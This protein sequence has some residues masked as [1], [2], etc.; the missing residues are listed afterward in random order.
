MCL[1]ALLS[2]MGSL[3]SRPSAAE[4][5]FRCENGIKFGETPEPDV[6]EVKCRSG[7]CGHAPG[8]VVLHRF[9]VSTGELISTARFAEPPN[10]KET[11]SAAQHY[12]AA[13][14]SA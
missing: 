7:Y 8:V 5:E 9:R 1:T 4:V 12:S 2:A 11:A 6:I 10:R 13:V 14:R 3:S